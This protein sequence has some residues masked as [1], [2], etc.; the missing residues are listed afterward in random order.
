MGFKMS[1]KEE[2]A[3][4]QQKQN[5]TKMKRKKKNIYLFTQGVLFI[6]S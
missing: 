6:R 1:P 3:E 5:K 2:A 4:H